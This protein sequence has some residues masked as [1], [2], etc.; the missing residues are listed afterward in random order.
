[1]FIIR[2]SLNEKKGFT[3]TFHPMIQKERKLFSPC[4]LF[5]QKITFYIQACF[6]LRVANLAR[7]T[8]SCNPAKKF[9]L[10]PLYYKHPWLHLYISL[11]LAH[12]NYITT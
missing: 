4:L 2:K 8:V 1:M 3:G 9:D 10:V 7:Q 6:K 12:P 11:V 5:L